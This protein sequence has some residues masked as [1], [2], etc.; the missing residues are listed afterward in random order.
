MFRQ[1]LVGAFVIASMSAPAAAWEG[2]T[3]K[4]GK[5]GKEKKICRRAVATGSVMM[6]ITCRTKAEWDLISDRSQA[7]LQRQRDM[8]RSRG[9]AAMNAGFN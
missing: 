8:E 6:K 1:F 5:P 7:D 3:T 9:G 4:A 2:E